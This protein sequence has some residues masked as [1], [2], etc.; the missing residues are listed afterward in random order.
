MFVAEVALNPQSCPREKKIPMC[1]FFLFFVW[2]KPL[3]TVY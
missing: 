3:V 1:I 2:R